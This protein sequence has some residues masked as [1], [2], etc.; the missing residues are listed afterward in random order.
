MTVKWTRDVWD[1]ELTVY[2]DRNHPTPQDVRASLANVGITKDNIWIFL[3]VLKMMA[4]DEKYDFKRY[5]KQN[6][7]RDMKKARKKKGICS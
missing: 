5:M 3:P 6:W 4:E 1:E 2:S 7:D